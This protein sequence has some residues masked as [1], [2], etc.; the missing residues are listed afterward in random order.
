M[1]K[2]SPLHL[3]TMNFN[4]LFTDQ[5]VPSSIAGFTVN[6]FSSRKLFHVMCMIFVC[7]TVLCP[8]SVLCCLRRM[9]LHSTEYRSGEALQMCPCSYVWSTETLSTIRHWLASPVKVE[10]KL[11]RKEKEELQLNASVYI[12]RNTAVK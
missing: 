8:C 2:L 12:N 10:V 6:C 7:F 9:P 1:N 3:Y 5:E 4:Q 11:K